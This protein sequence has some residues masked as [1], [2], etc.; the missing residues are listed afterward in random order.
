MKLLFD[1]N[2]SFRLIHKISNDFP[3]AKQ[4]RELG[5]DNFTD[6][7]I[8]DYAK[9]NDF[10]IVTFDADFMDLAAILGHPPKIIWIRTGNKT[11]DAL[12]KII[13]SK[14]SLINEFI[15]SEQYTDIACME[16]V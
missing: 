10:T 11:T 6:R 16:I 2:I 12:A 15:S 4:V 5:L 14:K 9:S 8:W 1:Q 3:Q 7:Q 13:V